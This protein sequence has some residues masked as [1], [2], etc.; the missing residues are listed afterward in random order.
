L[1]ANYP[2]QKARA[3]TRLFAAVM[4]IMGF[5]SGCRNIIVSEPPRTNHYY[6]NPQANFTTVGRVALLELDN[7]T[8]QADLAEAI[9]HT[10]VDEMGKR[11]LFSMQIISRS[12]PVWNAHNLDNMEAHTLDDLAAARQALG[13]DAVLFGTIRR[14]MSFPHLQIG[15]N[16]KMIDTRSGRLIWAFEDVWDS[17]DKTVENRMKSYFKNQMR[18]GY[19]PMDWQILITSPRAFHQFV[20]HEVAKTLPEL[21]DNI[22][23][24]TIEYRRRLVAPWQNSQK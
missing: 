4:L 8:P 20:G 21:P 9:T 6:V 7:R 13:A 11:N 5:C 12:D 3:M 23:P 22:V 14:Y 16:L 18:T 24:R 19:E 2:N 1:N 15:L 17:A 10:L